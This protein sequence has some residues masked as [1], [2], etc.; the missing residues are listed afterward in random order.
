MY[1][2]YTT[3]TTTLTETI[4]L[5]D[6]EYQNAIT[7][8]ISEYVLV[9]DSETTAPLQ[10]AIENF[11]NIYTME[12]KP[13]FNDLSAFD[14]SSNHTSFKS[15]VGGSKTY[16]LSPVETSS[17][18]VALRRS[19]WQYILTAPPPNVTTL[20]EYIN[21]FDIE[22]TI[23]PGQT[24]LQELILLSDSPNPIIPITEYVNIF[25]FATDV[26]ITTLS[27][28]IL[29][30]D[31]AT[32]TAIAPPQT[33][34]VSMVLGVIS[35]NQY[36]PSTVIEV[37]SAGSYSPTMQLST[38][39]DD[40]V[41]VTNASGAD[42]PIQPSLVQN[43]VVVYSNVNSLP[44]DYANSPSGCLVSFNC[45]TIFNGLDLNS[46]FSY[47]INLEG[48][49]GTW[50]FDTLLETTF[51][52]GTPVTLMGLSGV[53]TK[54]GF[55]WSSS[56]SVFTN[57]GIFG[58]RDM[59]REFAFLVYGNA[60]YFFNQVNQFV[61]SPDP[62]QWKTHAD[63]ARLIGDLTGAN[64]G[65]YIQDF[66]LFNFQPQGSQTGL[67]ALESLA[68]QCGGVVRWNG[69]DS[70]KVV[71]P[72]VSLGVFT[73]PD[74]CLI[75]SISNECILDLNSGF[76]SPGVRLVPQLG[77][78]DASTKE[79]AASTSSGGIFDPNSLTLTIGQ[80]APG[81]VQKLG[82]A[83]FSSI[84]PSKS[85]QPPSTY[86][87]DLPLDTDKV[88]VQARTHSDATGPYTV[89]DDATDPNNTW[90]FLEGIPGN[91][92]Y[93]ESG[94][95]V[96]LTQANGQFKP[97]ITIDSTLF[98]PP[99]N[100]EQ[101]ESVLNI[102]YS[103]KSVP[104][105]DTASGSYALVAQTYLKYQW[106]PV[107]TYTIVCTFWGAMPMPGMTINFSF[108]GRPISGTIESVTLSN[109]DVLT[110]NVVQ[111]EQLEFYTNLSQFSN[112]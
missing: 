36:S 73:I 96:S 93:P 1:A 20:Y 40:Y 34:M 23:S 47:S 15:V 82:S 105:I 51:V 61:Q 7:D 108:N 87:I 88:Y 27:E 30:L 13:T 63:A 94:R 112:R 29:I 45:S 107:C 32:G 18:H 100:L 16:L 54:K 53:T 33:Y 28:N 31:G 92:L 98:P 95:Y 72:N 39:A 110:I 48:A 106:V 71:Y 17:N 76:Y 26:G 2:N 69:L 41:A 79:L 64:I 22:S 10:G 44:P 58:P 70:Y 12:V 60:Q 99:S 111:W 55:E 6:S 101:A 75:I 90:F 66:P 38:F 102:A 5:F 83:N 4:V 9:T 19:A 74:C 46:I 37:T 50:S 11:R 84:D 97:I 49:G 21:V 25:D 81:V 56:R 52:F 109:P 67:Q 14:S 77:V 65:W 3:G 68:E 57:K 35:T 8:A 85:P 80:K 43:G 103:T 42:N 91:P 104:F 78:F 24:T 62:T 89:P 59:N 86:T